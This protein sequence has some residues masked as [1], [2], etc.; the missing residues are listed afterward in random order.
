LFDLRKKQLDAA[1]G[2]LQSKRLPKAFGFATLGYGNPPGSNFFKDEFAP[3]YI[4]GAGIKWNLF[5]W[6]KTRDEK[7]S[8]ALHHTLL[9]SRKEDFTGQLN[10]LLE[11]KGAEIAS[12]ESLIATDNQLIEL[13]RRITLVA[14]SQLS[15][16][17]ITASEYLNELN[18]ERQALISNELHKINLAMAK[19]E[20]LNICGKEIE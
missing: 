18:A 20:Y 8:M 4:I 2:L 17:I 16:G 19:V 6:N 11:G 5:D 7:Q 9:D 14:E 13:R 3:Y 15:S 12:L 1:M 10:R